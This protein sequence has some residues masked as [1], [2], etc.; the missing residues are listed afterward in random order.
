MAVIA[1]NISSGDS[2]LQLRVKVELRIN[3]RT[4]AFARNLVVNALNGVVTL[5]GPAPSELAARIAER[6][7]LS[8]NG[9]ASVINKLSVAQ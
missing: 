2:A 3:P 5:E 9:V 6:V 4:E 1:P 8:I 7:A